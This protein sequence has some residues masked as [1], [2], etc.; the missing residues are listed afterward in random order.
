M[1]L[2][3]GGCVANDKHITL[4]QLFVFNES[5]DG[6]LYIQYV[7]DL[8]EWWSH[9]ITVSKIDENDLPDNANH[10]AH[11]IGGQGGTIP[12]DVGGIMNYIRL[13]GQLTGQL[14]VECD[15]HTDTVDPSSK[16]WWKLLNSE[17]RSKPNMQ[18]SLFD[19]PLVFDLEKTRVD[20]DAALRRP[21]QKRGK[22]N[23]NAR[24]YDLRTGLAHELDETCTAAIPKTTKLCAVCGITVSLRLC[25]V[26]GSV[27][28]CGRSHQVQHWKI[29][30]ADCKRIQKSK[31]KK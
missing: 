21:T 23:I 10:V 26:C 17:V 7:H 11:L 16:H 27:A 30:K 8:G 18:R 12:D 28:Y 14:G 24:Q 9:S 5:D 20:I 2:Y 1:P 29:H 25:S 19:N 6:N 13:M 4:G 31:Q 22:E 3:I 15:N